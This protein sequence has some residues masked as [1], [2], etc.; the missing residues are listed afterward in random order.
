MTISICVRETGIIIEN[1]SD[2]ILRAVNEI[3]GSN[4]FKFILKSVV[5]LLNMIGK[6]QDSAAG[7]TGGLRLASLNKLSLNKTNSGETLDRYLV[8]RLI[9]VMPEIVDLEADFHSL[10]DAKR[11]VFETMKEEMKK[12]EQ[13]IHSFT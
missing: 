6:S 3:R 11:V 1:N 2:A 5:D 13:G 4:K 9:Q 7:V 10:E 8:Y 12:L